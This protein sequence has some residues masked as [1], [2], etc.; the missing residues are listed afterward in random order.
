MA[1]VP[2]FQNDVFISYAHADNAEGWVAR[3]ERR[4]RDRVQQLLGTAGVRFWRDAKLG[5][6]DVFSPEIDDQLRSSA[7]LVSI[8]S[9]NGIDSDA[10]QQERQ[11]F[12][13]AA[14]ATG[15]LLIGKG[16]RAVKVTKMPLA[17]DRHRAVFATLGFE[18]YER[19]P[20]GGFI[21]YDPDGREYSVIVEQLAQDICVLLQTLR[22]RAPA[23]SPAT[24]I[25]TRKTPAFLS[26]A[27]EDSAFALRV[28]GD[29]KR[30][31][32]EIWLDQ[33]DIRLGSRWDAETE[34]AIAACDELIVILSPK[35]VASSSVMD[36]VAFALQDQKTVIPLL[37]GDCDIPFRLRRLQYI[38]FRSEYERGFNDLMAVLGHR[39]HSET[40]VEFNQP[41]TRSQ[42]RTAREKTPLNEGK[43]IL[44]G[45]GGVGKTSLVRVL[46]GTGFRN[47]EHKTEG[48]KITKW[49]VCH[50]SEEIRLHIWD[51][52]GQE[53]MDVLISFF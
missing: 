29:L 40:P 2:S 39:S 9:P 34:R 25:S 41:Q 8:L 11:R 17:D 48:I 6:A 37:S 23:L 38:D 50:E 47:D 1:F 14:G 31:G 16:V 22:E 20:S 10:C 5:G 18:F 27:R 24:R 32:A 51:F 44:V 33:L 13:M 43:L 12:E 19:L 28:A 46:T 45:R 7:V 21:E 30:A 52:G 53:I 35:A 15:G 49:P 4:L 42:I 36:E 3:F 26:Y